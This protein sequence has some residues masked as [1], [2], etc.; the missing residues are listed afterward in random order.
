MQT[1]PNIPET[2]EGKNASVPAA[3]SGRKKR[4]KLR[5]AKASDYEYVYVDADEARELDEEEKELAESGE[6][7]GFIPP[8]SPFAN[9]L[10]PATP[11]PYPP[12]PP[13]PARQPYGY[14][15]F[16]SDAADD[17]EDYG[18]DSAEEFEEIPEQPARRQRENA[19]SSVAVMKSRVGREMLERGQRQEVM[20]ERGRSAMF[21]LNQL[22]V[23]FSI[24]LFALLCT[25]CAYVVKS[26]YDRQTQEYDASAEAAAESESKLPWRVPEGRVRSCLEDF[27]AALGVKSAYSAGD[28]LFLKGKITY[29]GGQLKSIYG[30][31]KQVENLMYVKAGGDGDFRAYYADMSSGAAQRLLDGG[32][33]G[34][35]RDLG[36]FDSV[37]ARSLISFDEILFAQ[38]FSRNYGKDDSTR[39]TYDG[40]TEV[41][42][43]LCR[44]LS[45]NDG[46]NTKA[47]FFF[48][49][50][51]GL[52]VRAVMKTANNVCEVS[53]SDYAEFDDGRKYP[54][55]RAITINSKPY[56][57][58]KFDI[59]LK[60]EGLIFPS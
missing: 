6:F 58:I 48:D 42:G 22:K 38:A 41:G 46:E 54:F 15:D 4:R 2:D 3:A 27:Y 16:D 47:S 23:V 19:A 14:A 45:F 18:E 33:A 29:A 25:T 50:R 13:I 59:V 21:W 56:A 11:F 51:T 8:P 52:L 39:I 7:G 24:A 30:I 34:T 20:V 28:D 44:T 53:Y 26:Y 1:P 60:R 36:E 32:M 40:E 17:D 49:V 35:K 43:V 9:G 10:P 31:V 5:A 37:V 12:P 57:T 55:T